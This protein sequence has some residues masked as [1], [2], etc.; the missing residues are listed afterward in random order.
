MKKSNI[1]ISIDLDEQNI[2]EKINW[3]ADDSPSEDWT[4][5]KAMALGFWGEN[6]QN[7]T[8]KIDLWTKSMEVHEMKQFA[9][10]LMSGM[11]QTVKDA[12]DD[13][14]FASEIE[15]LCQSLGKRLEEELKGAKAK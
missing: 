6:S 1:S 10:E 11:A 7:G 3:K 9:I 12:T 14:V 2:P 4:E 8:L 5:S 13:N 15:F